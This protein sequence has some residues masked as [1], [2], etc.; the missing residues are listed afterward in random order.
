MPEWLGA[1]TGAD[2]PVTGGHGIPLLSLGW[3]HSERTRQLTDGM[4]A[5]GLFYC[6]GVIFVN[7]PHM[8]YSILSSFN[9]PGRWFSTGHHLVGQAPGITSTQPLGPCFTDGYRMGCLH[10]TAAGSLDRWRWREREREIASKKKRWEFDNQSIFQIIK[11]IKKE[12]RQSLVILPNHFF[13]DVSSQTGDAPRRASH[14]LRE[15]M[16]SRNGCWRLRSI[17][18]VHII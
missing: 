17:I 8:N 4:L 6:Y 7:M 3:D 5:G 14:Q 12:S 9:F 16:G 15:N 13:P 2:L 10:A 18:A 11:I 1:M